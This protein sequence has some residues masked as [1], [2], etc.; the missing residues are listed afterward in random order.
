L[1]ICAAAFFVV[2]EYTGNVIE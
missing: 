1:H 2:V